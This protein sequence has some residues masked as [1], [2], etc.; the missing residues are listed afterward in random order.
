MTFENY[1]I[2]YNICHIVECRPRRFVVQDNAQELGF[3]YLLDGWY[4]YMVLLSHVIALT[5]Y[6]TFYCGCAKYQ[7]VLI[8]YSKISSSL[9][10]IAVRPADVIAD[11]YAQL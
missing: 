2:K 10:K 5:E 8:H 4:V 9:F 3:L 11:A 1:A 6:H 7:F